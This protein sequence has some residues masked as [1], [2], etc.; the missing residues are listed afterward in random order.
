[1]S[2]RLDEGGYIEILETTIEAK[3]T[4]VPW[5]QPRMLVTANGKDLVVQEIQE[6]ANDP[7]LTIRCVGDDV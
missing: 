3:K 2:R 6:D 4:D 7:I 5:I 1:M